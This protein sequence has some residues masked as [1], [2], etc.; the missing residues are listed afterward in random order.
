MQASTNTP[1]NARVRVANSRLGFFSNAIGIFSVSNNQSRRAAQLTLPRRIQ[2]TAN[3]TTTEVEAKAPS[4]SA[5]SG[6]GAQRYTG[7]LSRPRTTWTER[8]TYRAAPY[9]HVPTGSA[10]S[11]SDTGR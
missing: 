4:G 11:G 5:G 8:Q 1:F 2:S 10:A 6:P 3:G 9:N 7:T